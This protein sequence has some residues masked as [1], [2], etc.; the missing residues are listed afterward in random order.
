MTRTCEVLQGRLICLGGSDGARALRSVERLDPAS[1]TWE[2]LAPMLQA[3]EGCGAAVLNDRLYVC[4]GRS[5]ADVTESARV[6]A[7]TR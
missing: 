3:R 2:A 1:G 7:R 5:G 6:L 4:G